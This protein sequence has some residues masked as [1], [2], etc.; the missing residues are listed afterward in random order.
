MFAQSRA[1]QEV[2]AISSCGRHTAVISS[3]FGGWHG[4]IRDVP[5]MQRKQGNPGLGSLKYLQV[6]PSSNPIHPTASKPHDFCQICQLISNS[7]R[8]QQWVIRSIFSCVQIVSK[9]LWEEV[10]TSSISSGMMSSVFFRPFKKGLLCA[11]L[12][13]SSLAYR[14]LHKPKL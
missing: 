4:P 3:C 8:D 14:V 2:V 7:G 12:F 1:G 6:V 13:S 9:T 11:V 5:L 10:K